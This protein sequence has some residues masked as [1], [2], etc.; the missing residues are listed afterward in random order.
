MGQ[1]LPQ[2]P[3]EGESVSY[4]GSRVIIRVRSEQTEGRYASVEVWSPP[5]PAFG[6]PLHTDAHDEH[7]YVLEGEITFQ[8]GDRRWQA[9]T[10]SSLYVPTGVPHTFGNFAPVPARMLVMFSPGANFDRYF[11][12]IAALLAEATPQAVAGQLGEV[13]RR[14][15]LEMKGPPLQ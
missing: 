9:A 4:L 8:A 12:E 7:F 11:E 3:G 14:Y 13:A 1:L 6:P 15:G 5:A 2:G 10:G